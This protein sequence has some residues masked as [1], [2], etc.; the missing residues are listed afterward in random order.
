MYSKNLHRFAILTAIFAVFLIGVGAS[1]TSTGSGDAVPD[2]PLSY[3]TLFPRMAGGVLYEHGH[4][5]VA[6]TV[7]IL[8]TILMIWLLRS[9]QPKYMKVFGVVA[10]VAVILQATLGGLRVLVVSNPNLQDTVTGLFSVGHVEPVRMAIAITHATLA[11][12]VLCMTFLI[13]LFTSKAWEKFKLNEINT[14]VKI[15]KLYTLTFVFAF[16]QILIGALVRHTQSGNIIPDF[17]LSFG[18]LIP[19]FGNLPYE[20]NAPFPISYAEL[21]FK[22]AIHFAHR[23]WAFVVAGFGIYASVLAIKKRVE[24]L[25]QFAKVWIVLIILQILLGALVVWTKL[26]VPITILHVATG[27]TLFGTT[28]V[29]AVLSWKGVAVSERVESELVLTK[30]GG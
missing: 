20:P 23:V 3:G 9:K 7:A 2:W 1:V 29:L 12:I 6:G 28:L 15:A 26:S 4:R 22:V 11:E 5:L 8:I 10:F 16:I 18:R 24:L 25:S 21:Q 19:P 30:S 27:A 13:A 17:P 14:G